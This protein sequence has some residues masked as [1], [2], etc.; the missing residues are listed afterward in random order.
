M[1]LRTEDVLP[2]IEEIKESVH[3][4]FFDSIS[5]KFKLLFN[6]RNSRKSLFFVITISI[7]TQVHKIY[8]TVSSQPNPQYFTIAQK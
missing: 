5:Q 4:I 3:D 8:V 1:K 7:F 6:N 2:E